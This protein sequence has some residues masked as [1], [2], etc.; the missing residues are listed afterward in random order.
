MSLILIEI[1]FVVCFLILLYTIGYILYQRY[2]A[3]HE[4]QLITQYVKMIEPQQHI[5]QKTGV[6]SAAHKKLLAR[7]L[8]NAKQLIYFEKALSQLDKERNEIDDYLM[9]LESVMIELTTYY[10][11][12]DQMKQAYLAHFIAKYAAKGKWESAAI[13]RMLVSYLESPTV[14]LRENVLLAVCR[15]PDAKWILQVLHFMTEKNLFHH[16]KL[17]QDGLLTYPFDSEE[18]IDILW[19]QRKTFQPS[20]YRGLIGYITYKSDRYKEVFYEMLQEEKLDL[21]VRASLMRYFKKHRLKKAEMLLISFAS[22]ER[23]ALRIVAV[24]VLSAY[25]SSAVI[26][27]LKQALGDRNWHVRRN[28]SQ[29]LLSMDLPYEDIEDI[30]EGDD[31][32][33][34]EMLR[35]QMQAKGGAA[36]EPVR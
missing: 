8:H 32:Y 20:I 22:S 24:N 21:E 9:E 19:E 35:Y 31:Q 4:K 28:A 6:V 14:Y 36:H 30:L 10:K 2:Y 12:A 34:K 27:V 16:P 18:L 17:L 5:V 1:Y 33:A 11:K 13:Y 25:Q 29:S 26:A 7:K 3:R 23:A 15:Q